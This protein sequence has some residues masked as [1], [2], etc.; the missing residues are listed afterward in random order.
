V[1]WLALACGAS[2]LLVTTVAR[3][4]GGV[5]TL[6]ANLSSPE[7]SE[8]DDAAS[9]LAELDRPPA[10]AVPALLAAAR[11]EPVV[12][13]LGELLIALGKSGVMEALG[14]IQTH[15]LSPIE[16]V[17]DL[18]REALKLWLVRNRVLTED[19]DLPEPPHPFYEPPPRFPAD[20]VAGHSLAVWLGPHDRDLSAPTE[21]PPSYEPVDPDGLPPGYA[22]DDHP[23]W[24]IV[25]IGIGAFAGAYALPVLMEAAVALGN[26]SDFHE[27]VLIP[28]VGAIALAGDVD[29]GASVPLIFCGLGQVAG[30][31]VT[32]VGAATTTTSLEGPSLTLTPG[33]AMLTGSF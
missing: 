23:R 9:E 33:G 25:A 12:D 3:A 26:D 7:A 22:V 31:V 17:R 2:C 1:R 27:A 11:R 19:D 30:I 29:G 18:G 10:F 20:R 24:G 5:S 14:L 16:D 15:A 13:V 21:P 4:D 28:V 6:V 32:L 8:R